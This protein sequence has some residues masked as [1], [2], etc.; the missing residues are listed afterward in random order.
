MVDLRPDQLATVLAILQAKVPECE[1]W[2]FG[3]R[4]KW[5]AKDSSDLDLALVTSERIPLSVL[6]RL[7]QA[8][9]DSYLPMTVDVVDIHRVSDEFREIIER[10]K[11]VLQKPS[12]AAAGPNDRAKWQ[13]LPLEECLETLIDYRGKT[14]KKVPSGIP[15]ITAKVV[16]NGRIETLDE[17]IAEEDYDGWMRRGFPQAGDVLLTMEA[18]LGQVA[19]LDD[20][21]VALAQRL[22]ALRGKQG[23]LDN[24]YLKYLLQ[25][26]LVQDQL[27][28]RATGTTV[29]G[30]K[31]SELRKINLTLPPL[32]EQRAMA[33][34]LGALDEKIEL[35]RRMNETLEALAQSLF[36]FWFIDATQSALPKGWL[37]TK[38]GD[39]V[40]LEYGKS[41]SN[42]DSDHGAYP[43]YGTNGRIG[44]HST[45]LCKPRYLLAVMELSKAF[46]LAVPND[47][48]LEIRDE[49]GFFQEVRAVLA[50][51]ISEGG[52]KS[53]EELDLAVRQIVSRAISSDKVIDIFDAAGLKKPD[54]S[55]LSDEFLAEVQHL[56]QRNLAVELLQ[57]LLNNELKIRQRKFL[58]QSK[59]FAEMLE[60]T[61]RRY[62]NRTIEAAQVIAELIE[63]AKQMREGQKRGDKLGLTDDEVAFYDALETNDSAVKVLGEPTL[64]S[65]ARELVTHV[66]KSVTIDWTLRESAQAQIRVLVRRILRKYGY[67]P[68]KQE[69]ATQTVLEQAK[70]LCGDWAE[71]TGV[72]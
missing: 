39:L 38:W 6:G 42:Y 31:Q 56:P 23:L 33:Q 32:D 14:P 17:F 35:N 16:K 26:D 22:V 34:V 72:N 71:T 41:L 4:A 30:I 12:T 67:P 65:I 8:F 54:I 69:K 27:R 18:P 29:L 21:K 3:S 63:L 46:A 59:S 11:V 44:S 10:Q 57:K 55:I 51:S 64:K 53:P 60:A 47:A 15:L 40:N 48:A 19:Q 49:V 50:K 13:T 52:G 66:R 36:K 37:S 7:R 62:Q 70:L 43:V 45:P 24:W 9:A 5:T 61:I 1:V 28:A 20:R 25:S 2:A 68:D 58:V